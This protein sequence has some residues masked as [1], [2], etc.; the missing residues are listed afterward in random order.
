MTGRNNSNNSMGGHYK[1][2]FT[3]SN[4]KVNIDCRSL[5]HIVIWVT[6][7]SKQYCRCYSFLSPQQQLLSCLTTYMS[8][9]C[10]SVGWRVG[11]V[12]ADT[13]VV[14]QWKHWWHFGDVSANAS[15][16]HRWRVSRSISDTTVMCQLKLWWSVDQYATDTLFGSDSLPYPSLLGHH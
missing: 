2:T 7:K 14:C 6:L 16:T 12:L 5:F 10:R 1:R 15:T 11:D 3:F 13:S 9:V 8:V 4:L